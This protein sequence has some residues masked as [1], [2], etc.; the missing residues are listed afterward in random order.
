MRCS[1]RRIALSEKI[2]L[3]NYVLSENDEFMNCQSAGLFQG[4]AHRLEE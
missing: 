3:S 1:S 4:E 2:D